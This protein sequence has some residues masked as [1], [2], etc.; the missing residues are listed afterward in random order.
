[1]YLSM[2]IA[3]NRHTTFISGMM[4]INILY[5]S[6]TATYICMNLTEIRTIIIVRDF[7]VSKLSDYYPCKLSGLFLSF[8]GHHFKAQVEE[9]ENKY[10]E[11][12]E[13]RHGKIEKSSSPYCPKVT[14]RVRMKRLKTASETD[15]PEDFYDTTPAALSNDDP[16]AN[17]A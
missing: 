6:M 3:L 17:A 13:K 4:M 7:I 14:V 16:V 5:P 11:V 15:L 8:V 12:Y 2:L 1:M 9:I 10:L